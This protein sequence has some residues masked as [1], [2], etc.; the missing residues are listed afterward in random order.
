MNRIINIL[1]LGLVGV[2]GGL[3]TG[4]IWMLGMIFLVFNEIPG[5]KRF[6]TKLQKLNSIVKEEFVEIFNVFQE[7]G[8][9]K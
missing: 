8:K 7:L 9:V 3:M 1:L 2:L 4:L 6:R 5:S